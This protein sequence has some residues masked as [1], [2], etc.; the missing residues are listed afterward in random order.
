MCFGAESEGIVKDV[1]FYYGLSDE[2]YFFEFICR[3]E[4]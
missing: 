4:A 1:I 3:R 2:K